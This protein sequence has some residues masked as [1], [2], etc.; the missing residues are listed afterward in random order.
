MDLREFLGFRD[1][2]SCINR[3]A[4]QPC[5]PGIRTPDSFSSLATRGSWKSSGKS[6][7]MRTYTLVMIKVPRI[8]ISLVSVGDGKKT[9]FIQ[10]GTFKHLTRLEGGLYT[11]GSVPAGGF[12]EFFYSG[13]PAISYISRN[14]APGHIFFVDVT[15]FVCE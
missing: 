7:L 9:V 15:S 1:F 13:I 6:V 4:N 8:R 5:F 2:F 11:Q 10:L 3:D 14:T 12:P